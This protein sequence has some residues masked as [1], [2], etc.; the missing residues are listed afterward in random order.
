[1]L[2]LDRHSWLWAKRA[3][4]CGFQNVF[5]MGMAFVLVSAWM[6][7]CYV[8][9]TRSP[10]WVV[11]GEN[12]CKSG[13]RS[14][15]YWTTGAA[16]PLRDSQCASLLGGNFGRMFRFGLW[17]RRRLLRVPSYSEAQGGL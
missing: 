15:A 3:T 8:V 16:G 12:H 17:V 2:P 5:S 14:N 10:Q 1:M 6:V 4:F 13:S 7:N 11:V 9:L